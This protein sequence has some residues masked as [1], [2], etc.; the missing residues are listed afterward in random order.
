MLLPNWT[1]GRGAGDRRRRNDFSLNARTGARPRT[2]RPMLL[3]KLTTKDSI[4]A[5]RQQTAILYFGTPVALLSTLNE[6]GTANLAPMSSTIFV[7]WRCILGLQGNSKTVEN[8]RQTGEMVINMASVEQVGAVDRLAKTTGTFDVPEDKLTRGFRYEAR[9]FETAGLTPVPSEII[10]P[11]RVLECPIQLEATLVAE[12]PI[13]E[14]GPIEGFLTSFEMRVHRIY[15]DDSILMKGHENRIDPDKW[16]PL[17]FNFQQF[18]GL[19][20]SVHASKM[21]EISEALY[22]TPDM[23]EAETPSGREPT[24]KALTAYRHKHTS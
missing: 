16:R 7:S 1:M 20:S 11:P 9:K 15:A 21:G 12:R 2:G 18:Y 4:Y 13:D 10:A 24:Y 6:D 8:L 17:L 23:I 3:G 19:G 5:R 14:G 22:R